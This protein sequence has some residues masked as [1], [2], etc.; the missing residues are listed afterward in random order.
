MKKLQQFCAVTVLTFTLT[1]SALAGE[2]SSPGI[3][4]SSPQEC[5]T[6]GE[7]GMPGATAAG[8]ILTPGLT[9]LDPVTGAALSLLDSL[10]L[11]F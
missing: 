10:L 5:S 1:L 2:M 6:R 11:L 3:I 7:I 4:S 9:G 8:E